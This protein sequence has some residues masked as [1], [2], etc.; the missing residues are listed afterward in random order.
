[1]EE[2]QISIDRNQRN[3]ESRIPNTY[4]LFLFRE[5]ERSNTGLVGYSPGTT[6]MTALERMPGSP[7]ASQGSI[8]LLGV[9]FVSLNSGPP[10]MTFSDGL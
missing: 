4:F 7:H 1:M 6:I 9:F 5:P 3:P 8:S 10:D 2:H